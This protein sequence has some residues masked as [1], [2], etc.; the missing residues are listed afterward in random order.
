M[1]F[2]LIE[3][4]VVVAIIALLI[5][6]LVP[7][8]AAGRE[9]AR[10]VICQSNLQ[11]LQK[12]NVFYLQA[13]R[14]VFPPHRYSAV[15]DKEADARGEKHWFHL[16]GQYAKGKELPHCPTLKMDIQKDRNYWSWQYNAR[17][18]GYGYNAFFLGLFN[19]SEGVTHGTY[20]TGKRWWKESWVKMPSDNILLGDSNPK[21][22]G[23]WSSTLWWPYINSQGEGLNG[24]RHR[25]AGGNLVFNDG[26]AEFRRIKFINP[27]QDNTDQFIRYW[28]PLQRRKP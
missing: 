20:I 7:S 14:G 16:L 4:L 22:D 26:H 18:I 9:Q 17:N 2:T 15:G 25:G 23:E 10:R 27:A 24:T 6:V 12:A 19:H 11:Q 28:D 1:G 8:F 5:A 21:P 3:I 13:F